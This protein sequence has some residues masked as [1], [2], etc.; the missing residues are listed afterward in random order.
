MQFAFAILQ[1]RCIQPF[2]RRHKLALGKGSV[3]T[4]G[5]MINGTLAVVDTYFKDLKKKKN[6]K[7]G[8]LNS[9]NRI[10]NM[11]ETYFGQK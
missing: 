5:R 9:P 1:A 7:F 11:D 3:M 6:E 10:Y 2:V 4:P 8:L